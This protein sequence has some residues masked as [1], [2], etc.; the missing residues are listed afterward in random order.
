MREYIVTFHTHLS[1]IKTSK[2]L[3][4]LNPIIAPVPRKIS[5]SCGSCLR[6]NCDQLDFKKLDRDAHKV[7]LINGEEY[8]LVWL[9][10]E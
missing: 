7:F 4:N 9:G 3:S 8:K 2:A 10:E 5:S 1:A 6:I